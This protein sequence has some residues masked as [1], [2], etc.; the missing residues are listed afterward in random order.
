V[1]AD[2]RK[3]DRLII[4]MTRPAGAAPETAARLLDEFERGLHLRNL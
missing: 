2:Q 1:L 3:R 4:H